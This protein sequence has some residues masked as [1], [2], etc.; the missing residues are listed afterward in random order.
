MSIILKKLIFIFVFTFTYSLSYAQEFDANVSKLNELGQEIIAAANDYDKIS[1]NDKFNDALRELVQKPNT[2]EYDFSTL[3][4][5]SILSAHNLKIYNWAIPFADGTFEYF[6]LLQI[7]NGENYSIVELIDKSDDIK[8]PE[9]KTLTSKSWYGAL[10][11]KLIYA[12][13]LGK[14]T[15]T[16]LGWDGNNLLTNKKIIETI[17]VADN[18]M[19]KFGLPILKTKKRTKRRMIFEYSENAVMSLKYHPEIEKIVFDF[20][21]PSSSKLTGIYEYYG[22]ALNR[23][24]AFALDK[25]KW[26]YE[27][28]VNI[29]LD[30]NIKD[31]MWVNPKE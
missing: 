15:Y 5:I 18:G 11:Y 7:K 22:P 9:N 17:A 16:L 3:K 21:V 30:R 25:G 13:K 26:L 12:K 29:E 31:N 19:I 10:Y 23:F 2:F 8:T 6:A 14:N 1:A 20:L 27:E 28:D 24:D 4:T